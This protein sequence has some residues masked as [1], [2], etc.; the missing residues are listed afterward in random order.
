MDLAIIVNGKGKYYSSEDG[1]SSR[2]ICTYHLEEG[3]A[4]FDYSLR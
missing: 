3:N 2:D 4:L 1:E